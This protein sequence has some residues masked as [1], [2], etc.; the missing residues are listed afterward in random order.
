MS[1][2]NQ[3]TLDKKDRDELVDFCLEIGQSCWNVYCHSKTGFLRVF[4][5]PGN[6]VRRRAN[7]LFLLG[8]SARM[9]M[10]PPTG[11]PTLDKLAE[12][13]L[14]EKA[15]ESYLDTMNGRVLLDCAAYPDTPDVVLRYAKEFF[16]EGFRAGTIAALEILKS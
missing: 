2:Q 14:G 9:L 12:T 4:M 10:C 16:L 1:I 8:F 15:W 6:D 11:V 3:T 5:L 13:P 7:D